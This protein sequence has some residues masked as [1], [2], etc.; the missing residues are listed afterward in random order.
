MT[1]NSNI[2]SFKSILIPVLILLVFYNIKFYRFSTINTPASRYD[3]KYIQILDSVGPIRVLSVT[4]KNLEIMAPRT[5]SPSAD[6]VYLLSGN[7]QTYFFR[8]EYYTKHG[9][10]I[11]FFDVHWLKGLPKH[12]EEIKQVSRA[13]IPLKSPG[14]Q[15]A[16]T[17]GDA[18]V[19]RGDAEYFRFVLH[20]TN[21]L[22]FLGPHRDVFNFAYFGRVDAGLDDMVKF[23]ESAPAAKYYILF[24]KPSDD[25]D[26]KTFKK[27]LLHIRSILQSKK[28]GKIFW[29]FPDK[30]SQKLNEFNS[31]DNI[32]IDYQLVPDNILPSK[33][34]YENIAQKISRYIH[35]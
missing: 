4:N 10:T 14:S 18:L 3:W 29:V 15:T 26:F 17:I 27:I 6:F 19:C 35:Q 33:E 12:T 24:F 1:D 5:F 30:L 11:K 16:V 28:S 8:F 25:I 20:K 32:I 7:S 21:H 13:D 9:D 34:I 31:D 22:K 2:P 23:A